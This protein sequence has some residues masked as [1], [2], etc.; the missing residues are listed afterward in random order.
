MPQQLSDHGSPCST[1]KSLT[2]APRT[3]RPAKIRAKGKTAAG[4][5]AGGSSLA[6]RD[7]RS[8]RLTKRWCHGFSP[9]SGWHVHVPLHGAASARRLGQ[10]T[11]IPRRPQPF[12]SAQTHRGCLVSRPAFEAAVAFKMDRIKPEGRKHCRKLWKMGSF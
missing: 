8:R 6:R 7:A 3:L 2:T 9:A 11:G 12:V 10:G 4:G 1:Q 5:R